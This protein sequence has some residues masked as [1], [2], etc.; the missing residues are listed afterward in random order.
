[1]KL[2]ILADIHEHVENLRRAID[3]LRQHGADCLVVLAVQRYE[4]L[5][6]GR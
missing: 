1:M 3:V 5:A 2:G 6:T 4:G